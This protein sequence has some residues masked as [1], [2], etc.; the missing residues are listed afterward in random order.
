MKHGSPSLEVKFSKYSD[1]KVALKPLP[2]R[3]SLGSPSSEI[4]AAKTYSAED[5]AIQQ[6]ESSDERLFAH[7]AWHFVL[8]ECT[9]VLKLHESLDLCY[10]NSRST[11]PSKLE[12]YTARSKHQV[13]ATC[14][15]QSSMRPEKL[16]VLLLSVS[17]TET[18][19]SKVCTLPHVVF[20]VRLTF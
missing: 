14:L 1:R 8:C 4:R 13:S 20:M 7:G 5:A 11:L 19:Q 3:M 18:G 10:C 2:L 9:S 6:R 17:A 15:S 12:V 16:S